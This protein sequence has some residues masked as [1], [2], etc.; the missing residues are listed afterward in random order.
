MR[1]SGWQITKLAKRLPRLR[2]PLLIEG[3][4]GIG[5]VGKLAVDFM[6]E[7]L[8]ATK[9]YDIFSYSFPHSVFVN[10]DNLVELPSIALYY[11]RL[12][13][14]KHDLLLLTGDVQPIDEYSC[15]EFS[16]A[17]L[18]LCQPLGLSEVITLGG[19]GLPTSPGNPKVF[20]T[21]NSERM[22]KSYAKGTRAKNNLFG[23]VGPIVGVSGLLVGLAG[24]RKINAVTMLAE[25]YGHPMYLGVRG[26][27]HIVRLL[28][29]KL[30]LR[31][32][33]RRMDREIEEMDADALKMAREHP[34]GGLAKLGKS[35]GKETS[36]IG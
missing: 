36:Y 23:I 16:D 27:R 28:N 26:A 7:E 21:G 4:P 33:L 17:L 25:T 1:P 13:H 34:G 35:P 31:L 3:L 10:E 22:V 5:N 6:V 32:D 9:A 24:R 29:S 2:S 11:K 18:D 15:Y 14:C 8:G 12:G 30:D 19:I 20:I